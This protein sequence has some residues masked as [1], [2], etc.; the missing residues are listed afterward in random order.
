MKPKLLQ[1]YSIVSGSVSAKRSPRAVGREGV[2]ILALAELPDFSYFRGLGVSG[3]GVSGFRGLGKRGLGV[4]G[5]GGLKSLV[6]AP[7]LRVPRFRD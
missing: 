7:F 2:P 6:L 3:L 4:S 5:S 1:L